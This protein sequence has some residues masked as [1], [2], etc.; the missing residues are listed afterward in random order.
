M[1]RLIL[2]AVVLSTLFGCAGLQYELVDKMVNRESNLPKFQFAP[3][4]R[5][6]IINLLEDSALHKHFKKLSK[7][8]SFEK[9]YVVDW[10]VPGFI[11]D[12]IAD[13]LKADGRY[14][15]VNIPVEGYIKENRL[16]LPSLYQDKRNL[17]KAAP[18]L[19]MIAKENNVE[20]IIIVGNHFYIHTDNNFVFSGGYGLYTGQGFSDT[21][22]KALGMSYAVTGVN[23]QIFHML[24]VTYIGGGRPPLADYVDIEWPEDVHNLE[25]SELNKAK[26]I[27]LEQVKTIAS[28]AMQ[29][30]GLIVEKSP[31]K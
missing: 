7:Q 27:I 22:A 20:V 29:K 18:N 28:V 2:L 16:F 11:N 19:D 13:V 5:V 25:M 1:K 9:Y 10:N 3:G 4:T 6:G 24:P 17:K 31:R 12:Y 30:S 26:P 8:D 23:V 15:I 21:I 14:T